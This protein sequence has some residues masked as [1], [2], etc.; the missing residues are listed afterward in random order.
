M[1]GCSV[2]KM[3]LSGRTSDGL[4]PALHRH[5]MKIQHYV[6]DGIVPRAFIFAHNWGQ[7]S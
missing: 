6:I 3:A 1:L 7:F 2:A 4:M 5:I